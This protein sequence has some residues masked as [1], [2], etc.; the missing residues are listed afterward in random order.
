MRRRYFIL[1]MGASLAGCAGVRKDAPSEAAVQAPSTW[2][3][4]TSAGTAVLQADWW[5]AFDDASLNALVE[6]VLSH[7]DDIALAAVRVQEARAQFR[8][9][10]AQLPVRV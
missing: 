3:A 10:Q 7:S 2:R 8:Y 5:R 1:A 4:P 6:E 9:T